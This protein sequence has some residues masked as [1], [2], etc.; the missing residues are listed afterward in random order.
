MFVKTCEACGKVF[1]SR[2]SSRDWCSNDCKKEI[3]QIRREEEYQLCWQCKKACGGCS[4]SKCLIPVVGWTA[5]PTI[6]KDS[7]GDFPSYKI[8]KCPEFIKG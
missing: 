7:T 8:K 6:V 2:S 4:W 5:K 3:A 1:F